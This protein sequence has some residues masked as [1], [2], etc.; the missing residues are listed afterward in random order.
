MTAYS[1][2]DYLAT[3]EGHTLESEDSTADLTALVLHDDCALNTP[4]LNI[5]NEHPVKNFIRQ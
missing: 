3:R 4:L 5:N 2:H 1:D